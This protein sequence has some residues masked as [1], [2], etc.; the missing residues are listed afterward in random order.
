MAGEAQSRPALAVA[1]LVTLARVAAQRHVP[2][3][4]RYKPAQLG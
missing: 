2:Q 4:A 3:S 1:G